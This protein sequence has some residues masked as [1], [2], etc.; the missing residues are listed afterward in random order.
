MYLPRLVVEDAAQ[1]FDVCPVLGGDEYAVVVHTVHPCGPEF[2]KGDVFAGAWSEVVLV[3]GLV[4]ECV[5]FVKHHDDRLLS[6][7]AEVVERLVDNFNLVLECRVGEVH[8]MHQYVGLAHLVEGRFKRIDKMRGQFAYE[9]YG[10][11]EQKRQVL[12]GDF[13]DGGVQCGEE[14]VFG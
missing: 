11:G 12:D 14:L 8:H 3:F 13:P 1:L 5:D 6:P 7:F 4:G 10:V 9:S 2:V